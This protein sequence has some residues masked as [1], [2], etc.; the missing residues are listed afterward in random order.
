MSPSNALDEADPAQF[1]LEAELA[2]SCEINKLVIVG[3]AVVGSG[4]GS[5][6]GLKEGAGV[7]SDIGAAVVGPGVGSDVGMGDGTGVVTSGVG[8][9]VIVVVPQLS[10]DHA[11]SLRKRNKTKTVE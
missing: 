4:V 5:D 10:A 3:G 11:K 8:G 2:L 9:G 1:S 7:G 6:V